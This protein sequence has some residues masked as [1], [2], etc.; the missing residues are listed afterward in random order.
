MKYIISLNL[1]IISLFSYSQSYQIKKI[2]VDKNTKFPLEN[3]I[4]FNERDNSTT[5]ADGKFIFVSQKNEINLNVLGYEGVKTT[6]DKLNNANDTIFL[7]LKAIQLK[8]VVVSNTSS[9]MKNVYEKSKDNYLPNYT[10]NF[11]LRNILKKD[12]VTI[13]LQDIYGKKNRNISNKKDQSVEILNMRKIKLFEKEE[14]I[15]FKLPDF[16]EFFTLVIP[17]LNKCFFTEI[18]FNDSGFKKILFE[19]NEKDNRG[20]IW[21]GYFIINRNDYAIVEY[22]LIGISDADKIPYK[23][24]LL[25]S[26]QTRTVKWTQFVQFT[27]DVASNKY[28]V[29][30]SKVEGEVEALVNKKTFYYDLNM[31]YF[32]TNSPTNE[33]IK[34]N[35]SVDKDI[36]KADFSYSK[37]FW[38][39]Q[40]QLPLTKE[41]ELFLKSIAEKKDKTKEYK[42]IGN[43]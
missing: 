37:D 38:N 16:N 9:F 8:E 5:N 26:G 17:P 34:A 29:S 35:F 11:F 21:N 32:V 36:F 12:N 1:F 25:S 33:K 20:Q 43:F 14:D 41:L 3:V 23:K 39:N 6:F 22:N 7:Q 18:P 31:D 2:V 19:T 13:V 40:N 24:M 15:D 30:I 28:Y 4:I 42:V 10:A 27:K